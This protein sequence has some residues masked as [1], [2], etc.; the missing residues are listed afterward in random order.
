[1]PNASGVFDRD[2]S[3]LS[4]PLARI[5]GRMLALQSRIAK[6]A[7]AF[8]AIRSTA[9]F[10][11][12]GAAACSSTSMKVLETPFAPCCRVIC[13]RMVTAATARTKFATGKSARNNL[14]CRWLTSIE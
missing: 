13:R 5:N 2:D 12:F 3:R 9:G 10:D 1:M 11:Q 8:I 6:F 4:G 14:R 7:A